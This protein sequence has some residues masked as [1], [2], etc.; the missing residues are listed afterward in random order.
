MLYSTICLSFY[1]VDK[2]FNHSMN[3][4]VRGSRPYSYMLKQVAVLLLAHTRRYYISWASGSVRIDEF[5]ST[6][7]EPFTVSNSGVV[8][9]I[10]CSARLCYGYTS[11]T[12][13]PLCSKRP[14]RPCTMAVF[15]C[16][17]V[18]FW[19]SYSLDSMRQSL[20]R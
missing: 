16:F 8:M 4:A 12:N 14:G 1:C 5:V 18:I 9:N 3:Q 13:W 17:N 6:I 15:Y 20:S 19:A 10:S 2:I 11:L 7:Q